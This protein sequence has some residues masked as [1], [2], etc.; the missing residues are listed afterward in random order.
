MRVT[1][2]MLSENVARANIQMKNRTLLDYIKNNNNT[3]SSVLGNTYDIAEN[4][5][6][7]KKYEN[8]KTSADKLLKRIEILIS[9]E[10][11]EKSIFEK[12]TDDE[13]K[14]KLYGSI[15]DMVESY[16]DT[17]KSMSEVTDILDDCYEKFIKG[18]TAE[19]KEV[20]ESIGIT[21]TKDGTIELDEN[22]LKKCDVAEI[23]KIFG[24]SSDYMTELK[25]L[26]EKVQNNAE[27]NVESIS[28]K[29]DIS[30]KL[31]TYGQAKYNYQ[32]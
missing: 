17:I 6:N 27:A 29:Y 4:Y 25:A 14:K 8:T 20:L 1:T 2:R 12:A 13:G 5:N 18:V 30:G 21:I 9:K 32:C 11:K 3:F 23:E 24:S 19:N 28:D 16:N 10:D 22:K 31:Y 7:M 26:A 15:K